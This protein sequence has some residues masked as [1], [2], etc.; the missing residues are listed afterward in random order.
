MEL[1]RRYWIEIAEIKAGLADG[2]DICRAAEY[3]LD[4]PEDDLIMLWRA[5]TRGGIFTTEER[6]RIK[7]G[8][9]AAAICEVLS[10]RECSN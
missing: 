1:V 6:T 4:I 7:Q 2:G 10:L 9:F 8:E 5:P 3:Y